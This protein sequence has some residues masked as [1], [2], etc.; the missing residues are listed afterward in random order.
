MAKKISENAIPDINADWGKDASNGLPYSG[1]AVQTF[2]KKTL[3]ALDSD[4]KKKVGWWCWSST[5]DA[6]NFYHLWGF[7]SEDDATAY[8]AD[9]EGNAGLLLFDEALPISTVQGDSF[10]AYLYT[11]LSKTSDIVTGDGKLVIPL[12]YCSVRTSN[13]DRLN[14]GAVGT[15]IIERSTDGN[16]WT[17]VETRTGVLPSTDYGDTEN[18]ASVDIS[19]CLTSGKQMIRMRAEFSYVADDGTTKTATSTYVTVGKSVTSTELKITCNQNYTQPIDASVY[20]SSGF[21]ISYMVYGSVGKILHVKVES[22]SVKSE[23]YL[24]DVGTLNAQPYNSNLVDTQDKYKLFDHGVHTVTAWLTCDNGLGETLKSNVLVNRFMV[25][26][27]DTEGADLTKPY[28]LLQNVIS[29][30]SNFTQVKIC[31]YAVFS[32]KVSED[33]TIVNQGADVDTI[34]YLTAYSESFDPAKTELYFVS[35]INVPVG[36]N[37][38]TGNPYELSTPVEIE[39]DAKKDLFAYFRVYRRKADGTL[40]NFM[41]ESDGNA[42]VAISIDA[43]KSFAPT[44][45]AAFLV[46][47]KLRSN[48]EKNP[49]TIENVRDNNKIIESTW[50]GF[51]LLTDGWV[52]SNGIRVLRV[53]S[54]R[55][56]TIKYNPLAQFRNYPDSSMT[57]EM[58]FITRNILDEKTPVFGFFDTIKSTTDSGTVTTYRGL[59]ICAMHGNF[60][61]KSNTGDTTTD[62]GWQEGRRVRISVCINN[63]VSPNKGD[64]HVPSKDT[65]LDTTKTS[66]ALVQIYINGVKD[67]ELK[68][69]N[70]DIEEMTLGAMTNGGIQ[71]G[72]EGVDI[73]I[74]SLRCYTNSVTALT[75]RDILQNYISTLATSEEKE[76][77]YKRNDIF[78]GDLISRDKV[79]KLGKRTIT[80]VGDENFHYDDSAHKVYYRFKQYDV[81]GNYMPDYSGTVCRHSYLNE[82]AK[83][84]TTKHQGST[85]RTYYDQNIQTD[86]GK[87]K[88][89]IWVALGQLHSSIK[90]SKVKDVDITDK[91]GAVTGTK[92]IVELAE[93]LLG[94]G[95]PGSQKAEQYDYKE[96][97]G[98]GYVYVPDGWFDDVIPVNPPAG[99]E[100]G[101]GYYHGPGYCLKEGT[102]MFQK[103]VNKINI[104]SCNQSHLS[105]I[106]NLYNDVAK[107]VVGKNPLQEKCETARINKYTEP[108]YY[109]W[110][111]DESS[112]PLFRGPCT[113]GAGKMDKPTMGYYKKDCPNF[114]MLEGSDNNLPLLGGVVPFT[115]GHP[116][117][118][119]NTIYRGKVGGTAYEGFLFNGI[120]NFDFDGGDTEA[121]TNDAGEADEKPLESCIKVYVDAWNFLFLHNPKIRYYNG[122][123]DNFIVS[124]E[125]KTDTE[126]KVWCTEGDDA[127]LLKRYSPVEKTWVNAGLWDDATGAWG[128]VNLKTD[129]MTKSAYESSQHKAQFNLLNEDFRTAIVDDA[130]TYLAFYFN[131]KSVAYYYGTILHLLCGTDNSDKNTYFVITKPKDVSING[132]TRSV[133]QIEL[134]TDDVD[135]MIIIDNNGNDTHDYY[136]NRF[137]KL[138]NDGETTVRYGGT[139][140]VL[141]NLCEWMWMRQNNQTDYIASIMGQA[142]T[143]MTQLV[144]ASDPI[145]GFDGSVKQSVWGCLYKYIFY[146]QSYFVESAYNEAAR[147]RYEYPEMIGFISEGAGARGVRPITQSMGDILQAELQFMR[148]RLV[149]M[150]SY[151]C[152]GEFADGK[153]VNIGLDD[154]ASVF[155]IKAAPDPVTGGDCNY[156]FAL[157]PHQYIYPSANTGQS[158]VRSYT[159]VGPGETYNFHVTDDKSVDTGINIRGANYY[160]S[161]G[162]LGDISTNIDEVVVKGNRLV[163]FIAHPTKKSEETGQVAFSPKGLKIEALNITK[164]DI[165]GCNSIRGSLDLTG[166]DRLVSADARGTLLTDVILPETNSLTSVQLPATIQTV[167]ISSQENVSTLS[168][169]G[170]GNL[171]KFVLRNNKLIDSYTHALSIY[172]AKP[173]GLKQ[174]EF[175]NVQWNTDAKRCSMDMLMYFADLKAVLMGVIYMMA[176]SSDRALT[177][178]DKVKLCS[179][180]GNIDD[181]NNSLY[182][183]YEV[184]AIT[185]ISITRQTYLNETG[186]DYAFGIATRPT[187]GNNIAVKDGKLQ[188]KWALAASANQYAEL[189]DASMGVVHVNTLSDAKLELKHE[190]SLEATTIDGDSLSA[191]KMIGFYTHIPKV[192]D[193]AYA[194]GTLDSD[195]DSFREC[196]G[197]V[198]M[199]L[200]V[201]GSDGKT[202]TAYEVHVC[203]KED[204]YMQSTSKQ[205]AWSTHRWGLYPDNNNGFQS[206]ES[207]IKAA[208]GLSSV[209]D[210]PTL[211]NHGSRWNGTLASDEQYI[212]DTNFLDSDTEDG[213]KVIKPGGALSDYDGKGEMQK[214]VEHSQLIISQYLDRSLPK[215]LQE[216]ADAMESLRTENASATNPWRYD[217]FYYPAAYGCHLYEPSVKGV[218]ADNYKA[219]NWYMPACGELGRLYNFKRLGLAITNANE[220]PLSE[221][222]TPI[223]ANA[224]KRAGGAVFSFVN[225]W[226]WSTSE[227]NANYGWHVNFDD[228]FVDDNSKFFSGYVRPC[229][230]FTFTL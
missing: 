40:V 193:F 104:A 33:G 212:K 52:D 155:S 11:S 64:V 120:Q 10:T 92:K 102:P 44:K 17:K 211:P 53:P 112:T 144:S 132:E 77:V 153:D 21:P 223:F 181:K 200:P 50:E 187:T 186:K 139:E 219:G 105:G 109:F 67:R 4:M 86:F 78:D 197:I 184:R 156:T 84:L 46:N 203:G 87:V 60:Y 103:N 179:L 119:E 35:E 88:D 115:W 25:T 76:A 154:A 65:G 23:E 94:K 152:W 114:C 147:I 161:F 18:Y 185:K 163:E 43:S 36:V 182:I 39:T 123:F 213:Y 224:N 82:K 56:I 168:L 15:L 221:A 227:S 158:I 74:Y 13:G 48:S 229:T 220:N 42:L 226:Y 27:K 45:G 95:V 225:N 106:N 228:G 2:I 177:L 58:D 175:D 159:L 140:N 3:T 150:A 80:L 37:P 38:S 204:L 83:G 149:M 205:L 142:F 99:W 71:I 160:R 162:N 32:P 199:R 100:D 157:T 146:I 129:T 91:S 111:K 169:E 126:S 138:C 171:Q 5:I 222:V 51:N 209:F 134:E 176:A 47:P 22:G 118:K 170:Y 108:F 110:Q 73:D 1:Q 124:S 34:F 96:E 198:F 151:A 143:A 194:D 98:V 210:L 63:K 113:F 20:K 81:K 62:F 164:V 183:Q 202:V 192:G 128:T 29:S 195:W 69:S 125:A 66:L 59:R 189:K 117:C 216:L 49:A 41:S 89:K 145:D 16:T 24:L 137:N 12:R 178:T 97:N 116:S 141:F 166:L 174:V 173:A 85:A 72:C 7:A 93:G 90:Q 31:D 9:H 19:S 207:A 54:G 218:L 70:T 107:I 135:S 230:A 57:F 172:A 188:L 133:Y 165:N 79:E 130:C 180:Y 30:A 191:S 61:T 190:L 127:Y 121:F 122:I 206:S 131:P 196:I 217:E 101:Y 68:F 75:D 55:K 148:R 6:S 208:T 214:I 215:T 26:N 201:Y 8:M 167:D 28:L 136:V 14:M